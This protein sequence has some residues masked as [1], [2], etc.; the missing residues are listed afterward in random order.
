MD[1]DFTYKNRLLNID[2]ED[3]LSLIQGFSPKKIA[4]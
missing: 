4:N 3:N 2:L 1:K